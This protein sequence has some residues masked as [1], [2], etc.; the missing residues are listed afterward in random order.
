MT[1][2]IR[3]WT[4]LHGLGGAFLAIVL[5]CSSHAI[6]ADDY[7]AG[8]GPEIGEPMPLLAAMDHSGA[9]RNLANLSGEHGLLLFFNRSVDW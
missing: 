1:K 4:A 9:A 6:A 7:S 8:W 3:S 5:T 2:K